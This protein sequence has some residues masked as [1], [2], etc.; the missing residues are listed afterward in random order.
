VLNRSQLLSTFHCFP[1]HKVRLCGFPDFRRS[2][3]ADCIFPIRYAVL[4]TAHTV[5]CQR[6]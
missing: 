3:D 4:I 6:H 2:V 5:A 1:G